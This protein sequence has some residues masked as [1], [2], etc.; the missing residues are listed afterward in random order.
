M[1]IFEYLSE[2]QPDVS[3]SFKESLPRRATRSKIQRISSRLD[4]LEDLDFEYFMSAGQIV[5]RISP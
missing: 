2:T 3:R 5:Q 4:D 1:N